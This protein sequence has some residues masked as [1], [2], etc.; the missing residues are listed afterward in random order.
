MKKASNNLYKYN[1]E[2]LYP[3]ISFY[4]SLDR[5]VGFIITLISNTQ[6]NVWKYYR[7]IIEIIS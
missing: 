1:I 3:G 5:D 4:S 2:G 6:K 7:E